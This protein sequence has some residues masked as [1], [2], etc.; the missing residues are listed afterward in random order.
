[1]GSRSKLGEEE[2]EFMLVTAT[3]ED[4]EEIVR[5]CNR[6]REEV[7]GGRKEGREGGFCFLCR[8]ICLMSHVQVGGESDHLSFGAGQFHRNSNYIIPK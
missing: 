1:M 2:E 7:G 8:P 6:V 4:A 5:F 3:P